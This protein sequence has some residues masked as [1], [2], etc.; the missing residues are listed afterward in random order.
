MGL[1]NTGGGIKFV[2]INGGKFTIRLKDGDNNPDAVER[3]LG[4]RSPTPGKI[5]RELKFNHLDG[6]IIGGEMKEGK[7]GT[8]MCFDIEDEGEIFKLQIGLDSG[9][10]GQVTKRL[11]NV[12]PSERV[13]FFIG[14][15]SETKK[16]YIYIQQNGET[17]VMAH[18]LKEPNG[19][20]MRVERTV[21]GKVEYDYTDQ[22]NFL[23]DVACMFLDSIGGAKPDPVEQAKDAF[24]AT[25]ADE[26]PEDDDIPF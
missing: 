3:A 17:C 12:D 20:P 25:E 4:E 10:F 22:E 9:F 24:G 1:S 23:Y 5:V 16:P 13:D 8:D 2:T 26:F 15:D 6:K 18:T 14:T 19:M 11:P 7:Y 21:K